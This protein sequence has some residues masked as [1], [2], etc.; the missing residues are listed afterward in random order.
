MTDPAAVTAGFR[1]ALRTCVCFA[2][3]AA[4]SG[5]AISSSRRQPSRQAEPADLPAAA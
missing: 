4:V 3:L 5:L 2:M 1:Q